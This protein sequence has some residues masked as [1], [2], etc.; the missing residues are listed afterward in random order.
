[1][2]KDSIEEVRKALSEEESGEET[3]E[4]ENNQVLS[5]DELDELKKEYQ[6]DVKSDVEALIQGEELSE[7]FKEK[8]ATIFE[9]QYLQR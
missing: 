3:E 6:I 2:D 9:A 1:M 5:E 7:E 8:A 4:T